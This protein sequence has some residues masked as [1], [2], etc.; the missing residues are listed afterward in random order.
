MKK[1]L[2]LG[3][4]CWLTVLQACGQATDMSY[5]LMLDGLYKK[6]VPTVDPVQLKVM[7]ASE[8][9][10]PLLLDTRQQEEYDVSHL[11]GARFLGYE[12]FRVEQLEEVPKDAPIVLYCSVGYRSE[13]VGEQL[14]AA[15]YTNVR[16]LY[17]GLFEWV[18]QGLPV[19]DSKGKTNRVHAYSRTWGVWLQKGEKVY[20]KE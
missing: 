4:V 9:E 18:N 20:G 5:A 11:A 1:L 19:Y 2:L 7:L 14:K 12:T 15:G 10:K 16:H 3:T 8:A 17:G 13:R 6:T